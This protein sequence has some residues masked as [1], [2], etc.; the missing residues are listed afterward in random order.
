MDF[1]QG[2][3]EGLLGAAWIEQLATVLGVTGVWLMMR[4]II[5]A[6]PVGMVQ[7]SLFA[8]VCWH[9]R[10][11][12]EV[13]LQG[14]FLAVLLYGWIHWARGGSADQPL[15]VTTL[16]SRGRVG[17]AGAVILLWL[18]WGTLMHRYTDAAFAYADA[19]VLAS[20]VVAQVLQARKKLENWLGWVLANTVAVGV[21]WLKGWYWFTLLYA[22]F[23]LMAW[24][25][26]AEWRRS[27]RVREAAT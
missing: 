14:V 21:F 16:S 20:S 2:V 3:R 10:L 26:W 1:W 27:L 13:V 8:W 5:W 22:I 23:W 12:S 15:P 19:L 18:G 25:G 7:V 24:G 17:C 11:Y 6:F 9:G 4:Q